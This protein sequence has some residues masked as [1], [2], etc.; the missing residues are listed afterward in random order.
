MRS[1]PHDLTDT[2]WEVI[3]DVFSHQCAYCDSDTWPGLPKPKLCQEHVIPVN[4]GGGY[5][6][7]NIVPACTSCNSRK[8]T[9]DMR[10]WLNNPMRYEAIMMSIG[11]AE[12]LAL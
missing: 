2:E 9:K 7:D 11:D 6:I 8:G 3:L 10:V 4:N 1:L 5:T 12:F